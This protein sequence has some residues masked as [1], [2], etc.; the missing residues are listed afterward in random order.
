ML[1]AIY[2]AQQV[3]HRGRRGFIQA[4]RTLNNGSP[5]TTLYLAGS[6]EPVSP[7]EVKLIES[8]E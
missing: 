1:R 6:P 7:D 8:N 3:E 5:E 2:K 4:L